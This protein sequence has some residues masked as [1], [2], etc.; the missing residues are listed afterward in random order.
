MCEI[1][2]PERCCPQVLFG[3]SSAILRYDESERLLIRSAYRRHDD[4]ATKSGLMKRKCSDIFVFI[5]PHRT[6]ARFQIG[7]GRL[8][9]RGELS[10]LPDVDTN[11]L[12]TLRFDS[13][14]EASRAESVFRT[15]T[16]RSRI[17][18][19]DDAPGYWVDA[20]LHDQLLSI[21]VPGLAIWFGASLSV[22]EVPASAPAEVSP[23]EPTFAMPL[24]EIKWVSP[25][26]NGT[27][28]MEYLS[29]AI[30]R[31]VEGCA[32][33]VA[34]GVGSRP[35]KLIFEV[36]PDFEAQA[37]GLCADLTGLFVC[38]RDPV[39][40]GADMPPGASPFG[41]LQRG[42][43]MT[44]AGIIDGW[45]IP[46]GSAA[47]YFDE[48]LTRMTPR[49]P[50]WD[51]PVSTVQPR[52]NAQTSRW[53]N[54]AHAVVGSEQLW[55]MGQS[56][57]CEQVASYLATFG[58]SLK[59]KPYSLRFVE[60]SPLSEDNGAPLLLVRLYTGA[61]EQIGVQRIRLDTRQRRL[62]LSTP[63]DA[64]VCARIWKPR[65]RVLV[66][67]VLE[68]ALALNETTRAPAVIVPGKSHLARFAVE[69]GVK[70]YDVFLPSENGTAWL[71]AAQAFRDR[72]L[73]QGIEVGVYRLPRPGDTEGEH[74]WWKAL[75]DA[76]ASA[77]FG[78]EQFDV[79]R[80]L[81]REQTPEG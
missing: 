36:G 60:S 41:R 20:K 27:D 40:D 34:E 33:I 76:Q 56:P 15:L 10:L 29:W 21:V 73:E 14:A 64:A 79:Y 78:L 32:L 46:V 77:S 47:D 30:G 50:G 37:L 12:V 55:R 19:P 75:A 70:I 80:L 1:H 23:P 54:E 63:V 7:Q 74:F 61:G 59:W 4:M 48:L 38:E 43:F 11:G 35:Q 69:V 57:L 3:D 81:S 17:V 66:A 51:Q 53:W 9:E 68:D 52:E 72:A 71:E 44:S 49:I 67:T 6:E 65:P 18:P 13:P 22:P 58:V 39:A 28:C 25:S 2:F 62:L 42:R 8:D 31:L 45:T 24:Q 26:M 5:V 16:A